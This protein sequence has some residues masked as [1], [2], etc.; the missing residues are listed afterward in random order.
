MH[1]CTTGV[2]VVVVGTC[3]HRVDGKLEEEGEETCT[4]KVDGVVEDVVGS[5]VDSVVM[6]D[7]DGDAP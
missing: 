7:V 4:C 3:T 5:V 2:V 6:E 1:R